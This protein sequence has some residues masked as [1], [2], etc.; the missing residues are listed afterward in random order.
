MKRTKEIL[1]I[2]FE[3]LGLWQPD[4]PEPDGGLTTRVWP[5]RKSEGS[6]SQRKKIVAPKH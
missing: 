4:T 5:T 6:Q 3:F 2:R 1:V